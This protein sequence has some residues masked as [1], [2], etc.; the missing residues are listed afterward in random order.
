MQA[1]QRPTQETSGRGG[2]Y[3]AHRRPPGLEGEQKR[4]GARTRLVTQSKYLDKLLHVS[5]KELLVILG[6]G[7]G[8]AALLEFSLCVLGP[9]VNRSWL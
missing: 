3:W 9:V 7:A 4:G 8:K 6:A 1:R 2:G 5:P